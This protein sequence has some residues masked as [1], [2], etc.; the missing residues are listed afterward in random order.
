ML[1]YIYGN[2]FLIGMTLL[3]IGAVVQYIITNNYPGA[4]I[5]SGIAFANIG[6]LWMFYNR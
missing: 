6:T 2:I 3:Q 5:F 1:N 4:M